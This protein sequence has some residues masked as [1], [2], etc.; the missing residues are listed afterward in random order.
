METMVLVIFWVF[1]I[2]GTIAVM[3]GLDPKKWASWLYG[4]YGFVSGFLIG[5][6]TDDVSAGLKLGLLF[7][8]AVMWGYNTL[9]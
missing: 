9:E 2:V 3:A 8:V 4:V 6:L 1:A 5:L 7:A